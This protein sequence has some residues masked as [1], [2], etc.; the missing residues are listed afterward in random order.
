MDEFER[1]LFGN[2]KNRYNILWVEHTDKGR[3]ELNFTIPKIDLISN[4]AFNPY[5]HKK[6]LYLLDAWQNYINLRF[7][8]SD[9]KDPQKAHILQGSRKDIGLVKK[10]T[11]LEKILTAKFTNSEFSCRDDILKALNGSNIK[12]TRAG[13][14]YIS[15]KLSNSKKARRFKGDMF[16][17]E[18]TSIESL[19]QL[20]VK[21]EERAREFKEARV[22]AENTITRNPDSS[23][24]Q[25]SFIFKKYYTNKTNKEFRIIRFKQELSRRD[26]EL[27]RLKAKFD[28]EMQT[29]N[30]WLKEQASRKRKKDRHILYS[31]NNII[32]DYNNIINLEYDKLLG[33]QKPKTDKLQ[34]GNIYKE[35]YTWKKINTKYKILSK[36][37]NDD[38]IRRRIIKRI[39]DKREARER[40]NRTI[41]HSIERVRKFSNNARESTQRTGELS[42]RAREFKEGTKQF[43]TIATRLANSVNKLYE[44][45]EKTINLTREFTK[46]DSIFART[47][48]TIKQLSREVIKRIGRY[49]LNEIKDIKQT[50][51]DSGFD[52]GI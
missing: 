43:Q 39:R 17:E 26:E 29:R 34:N 35:K 44:H 2:Y 45:I 50:R 23:F 22:E 1:L 20:R 33:K 49:K 6:D 10:Y 3:L 15:I 11:E 27:N 36:R 28:K 18:F 9:P 32:N 25:R 51:V 46:S 19:E 5:Y 14:D 37:I 52:M 42:A 8:F 7:N 24:K 16:N 12:V 13:K 38:I 21:A 31:I 47:I 40:E 48:G 41:K 30:I 4:L